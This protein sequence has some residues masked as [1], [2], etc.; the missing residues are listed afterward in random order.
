MLAVM[1]K[2]FHRDDL[3]ARYD[4]AASSWGARMTDI[5]Y[6]GAYQDF[7]RAYLTALPANSTICDVGCG[8]GTF[9]QAVVNACNIRPNLTLVDPSEHMLAQARQ[10]LSGA[11]G[12]LACRCETLQSVRMDHRFDVVL[13]A[14]VL[15]HCNDLL[16]ALDCLF[17]M[18]AP[19]GKLLMVINRPHWCQWIIWLRWRHRWFSQVQVQRALQVSAM[20]KAEIHAFSG[21]PPKHTSFGY[22]IQK[23]QERI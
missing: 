15:E 8:V 11:T 21:G 20:P 10:R 4:K 19:G 1:E 12:N 16:S 5:G 22:F 2:Y 7:A 6:G 17:S 3:I 18:V 14:H 23:T 9:S 13:A